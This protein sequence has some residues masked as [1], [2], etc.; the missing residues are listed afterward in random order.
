MLKIIERH[1]MPDLM[2]RRKRKKT[3]ECADTELKA[4]DILYLLKNIKKER[5]VE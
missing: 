2:R 5:I 1:D 3:N 4:R